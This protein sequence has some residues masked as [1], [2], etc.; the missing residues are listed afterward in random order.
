MSYL[1]SFAKSAQVTIQV[2]VQHVTSKLYQAAH[3]IYH[4]YMYQSH[5]RDVIISHA[6]HAAKHAPRTLPQGN[7]HFWTLYFREQEQDG[8]LV[9][10]L[11]MQHS[12]CVR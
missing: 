2:V 6:C 9:H 10:I 8:V 12:N 11:A 4:N 5:N 7:D 1:N 3:D